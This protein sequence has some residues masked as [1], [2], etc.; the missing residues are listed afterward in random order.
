MTSSEPRSGSP[1]QPSTLEAQGFDYTALDTETRIVV[2]QRTSEIKSLMRRTAQDIIDI[3]QKLFEVKEQLEHGNFRNWLKVEFNWS[4]S[5]ATKFMQ[6][7]AQFKCV[8]FTHLDITASA[9]Y[10]LAAPST[11]GEARVEALERASLG[12]TI[13]HSK[14]KAIA[15]KHKEPN[16][17]KPDKPVT[18]D[19]PAQTVERESD[20]AAKPTDERATAVEISPEPDDPD[21]SKEALVELHRKEVEPETPPLFEVGNYSYGAEAASGND[22]PTKQQTEVE[23][24]SLF[25]VGSMLLLTDFEQR[26][27]KW[28]GKISEVVGLSDTDIQVIVK[29]SLHPVKD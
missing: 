7:A 25:E 23:M 17:P 24:E 11:P 1:E 29:I 18:V 10:L 20:T 26:S 22:L 6:V 3:G 4:I 8:K 2:Q 12:E 9:L 28:L 5:T 19:V 15:F 27:L 21:S 13:T 14:A 16:Q